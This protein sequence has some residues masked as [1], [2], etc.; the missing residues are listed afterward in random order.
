[1]ATANPVLP[2][3]CCL[4]CNFLA[5]TI[6]NRPNWIS[7]EDRERLRGGEDLLIKAQRFLGCYHNIWDEAN[8]LRL[9]FEELRRV[10]VKDRGYSC[11]FY[12]FTHGLFFQA[13]ETL[14]RRAAD[15]REAEA[16]RDLSREALELTQKGLRYTRRALWVAV[17]ALIV[18]AIMSIVSLCFTAGQNDRPKA[19]VTPSVTIK[20]DSNALPPVSEPSP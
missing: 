1:M 16:D 8:P 9:D 17:I 14:E 19:S 7:R 6:E 4:N 2:E 20:S 12:Q 10:L 5:N 18:S 3:K 15:R 13:A 11:F